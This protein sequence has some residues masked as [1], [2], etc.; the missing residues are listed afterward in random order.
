VSRGRSGLGAA[1]LSIEISIFRASHDD[2]CLAA[3]R[4][5]WSDCSP[6]PS[7]FG[8]CIPGKRLPLSRCLA[9]E[10]AIRNGEL[11]KHAHPKTGQ[12]VSWEW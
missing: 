9:P 7:H 1:Y 8:L 4:E 5:G 10:A 6:V 2:V 11:S 3:E 12:F